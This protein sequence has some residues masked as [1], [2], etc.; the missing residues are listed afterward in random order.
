[1]PTF[2]RLSPDKGLNLDHIVG[3]DYTVLDDQTPDGLVQ[4]PVLTL[5]IGPQA[6]D[7]LLEGE[8]AVRL[9]AYL[10][11]LGVGV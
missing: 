4:L 5:K 2:I 6:K 11:R 9:R 8:E 7:L 10:Q 3:W 1:M